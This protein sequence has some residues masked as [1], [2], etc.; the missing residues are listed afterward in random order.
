MVNCNLFSINNIR[1]IYFIDLLFQQYAEVVILLHL[2]CSP[3]ENTSLL[4]IPKINHKAKCSKKNLRL[5]DGC[6]KCISKRL[7]KNKLYWLI[8][9]GKEGYFKSSIYFIAVVHC[10]LHC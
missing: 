8:L 4:R 10:F 6:V 1:D 3:E 9:D 7:R 2:E 5:V